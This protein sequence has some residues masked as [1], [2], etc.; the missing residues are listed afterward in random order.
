MTKM[1]WARL[2]AVIVWVVLAMMDTSTGQTGLRKEAANAGALA[3]PVQQQIASLAALGPVHA[4][5]DWFASNLRQ[6]SDWQIDLTRVPAPPFGESPRAEWM[7]ARFQQLGLDDVHIDA[8]GNVLGLRPGTDPGGKYVLL[9]AHLDTVFP[10]ATTLDIH[11]DGEKLFGPGISDNGAGLTALLGVAASL[12]RSGL[13]TSSPLLF[14]A[15]VGEEGEGDLRGMRY[16]FTDPRWKDAIAYTVVLDGGGADSVVTEGLGSRR[17]QVTVKG[18][19]GHSWSDFGTPNPIIVL[20][21]AIDQ[22]S[23]TSIPANPKTTFNIGVISGGTS[24]NSI[25]ESAT[26]K[27]DMRSSS[28]VEMDR[29]ERALRNALEQATAEYRSA[30]TKP[31]ERKPPAISYEIKAIGNRPA[32]ELGPDSRILQVLRAVDA[33]LHIQTRVQRASTDA[34]IPLSLGRQAITLGGGGNGGGA[35]TLHEWYDPT[36]RDL[37]LKRILL[38]VLALAG[39]SQ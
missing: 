17:F 16:I 2:S 26:I 20:A 25:P 22:F 21:R 12:H 34:N 37:G 13:K 35:H 11:R 14:A 27:V 6:L 5:F 38:T 33:Q 31:S 4:A 7:K 18:P 15:N 39:V 32:A 9:S 30:G 19:G 3:A 36:N 23:R 1:R 10:S 28:P 24:V 8:E 29:M